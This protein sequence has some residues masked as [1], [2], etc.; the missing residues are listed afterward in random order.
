[1]PLGCEH[2]SHRPDKVNFSRPRVRT[3]SSVAGMSIAATTPLDEDISFRADVD[4]METM[5]SREHPECPQNRHP[6]HV[7][8]IQETDCDKRE[9]H[10]SRLPKSSAKACFAQ[11]AVTKKKCTAR[12]V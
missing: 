4:V 8:G 1:M 2:D 7:R 9:W 3:R 6:M 10:I 11:Q 5:P 12:I